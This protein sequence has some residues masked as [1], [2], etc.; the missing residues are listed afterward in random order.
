VALAGPKF[1]TPFA[2]L[3]SEVLPG[4]PAEFRKLIARE[5]WKWGKVIRAANIKASRKNSP[6]RRTLRS[7]YW[8]GRKRSWSN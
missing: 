8:A 2:E 1:K 6:L 5:P 7:S 4:L 3:G